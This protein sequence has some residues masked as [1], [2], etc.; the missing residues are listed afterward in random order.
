MGTFKGLLDYYSNSNDE[1]CY[2]SNQTRKV[3]GRSKCL[4]LET[5]PSFSFNNLRGCYEDDDEE[6]EDQSYAQDEEERAG[7]EDEVETEKGHFGLSNKM[8][9]MVLAEEVRVMDRIWNVN[10]EEKRERSSEEM[11][12]ARGPGIDCGGNGNGGWGG[13]GGRSGGGSGGE[14]DSG[15][16]DGGDMHGTEEYYKRMVQENPWQPFGFEKLCSIFVSD[17]ERPSGSRGVLLKSY[18]SRS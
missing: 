17:K 8:E 15:G 12:L 14:F 5:I 4:M 16:G 9:N 2:N 10:L 7:L 11:H 6:Y 13:F 18:L 3:S 1:Q